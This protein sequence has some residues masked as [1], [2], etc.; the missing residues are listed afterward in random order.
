MAVAAVLGRRPAPNPATRWIVWAGRLVAAAG[1][2]RLAAGGDRQPRRVGGNARCRAGEAHRSARGQ[3]HHRRRDRPAPGDAGRPGEAGAQRRQGDAGGA[4]VADLAVDLEQSLARR[5][6]RHPAGHRN[7]ERQRRGP[8]KQRSG[9]GQLR[10]IG[11]AQPQR[12]GSD[13]ERQGQHHGNEVAPEGRARL[14][15]GFG[16]QVGH[17]LGVGRN[18]LGHCRLGRRR[19]DHRRCRRRLVLI[20]AAVGRARHP[21][22]LAIGATQPLALSHYRCRQLIPRAA[23]GTGNDHTS[24]SRQ[25]DAPAEARLPAPRPKTSC[26][27]PRPAR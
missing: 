4:G 25:A 6:P 13:A 7:G 9:A 23:I 5:Q 26:P 27:W 16:V 24:Q 10:Q 15:I 12:G 2:R 1:R 18:G 3:F 19:D 17:Q 11:R 14:R 8:G 20:V 22:V 21:A